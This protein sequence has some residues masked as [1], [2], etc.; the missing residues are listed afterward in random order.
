MESLYIWRD[1]RYWSKFLFGTIPTPS[2]DL[3]FKDIDREIYVKV[4]RQSF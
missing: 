4:L 3:E 2:Y 1:Y